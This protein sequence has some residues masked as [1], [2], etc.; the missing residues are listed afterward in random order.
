MI[1]SRD[2]VVRRIR[3]ADLDRVEQAIGRLILD[4]IRIST[5][6]YGAGPVGSSKLGGAPDLPVGEAWPALSGRPLAFIAQFR[7]DEASRYDSERLLPREGMM[8][9]FYD[10]NE[11]PWGEPAERG[12]WRAIYRNVNMSALEEAELPAALPEECRFVPRRAQFSPESTL[13]AYESYDIQALELDEDEV[14]AYTELVGGLGGDDTGRHRLLGHPDVIQ[15]EMETQ[16]EQA[17]RAPYYMYSEEGQRPAKLAELAER[18]RQ[19][20]LLLQ[21]DSEDAA[22]MQWGDVGRLYYWG[23]A[24]SLREMN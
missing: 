15:N 6:P 10:A 16:C 1:A 21:I 17:S 3:G 8:W 22:G 23:R 24:D 7:M 5:E 20:R 13:R 19:W 14:E 11:Q 2:E 9:F 18:A 4:S 12:G